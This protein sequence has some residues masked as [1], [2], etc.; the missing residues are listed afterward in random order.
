[1]GFANFV[2]FYCSLLQKCTWFDLSTNKIYNNNNKTT[3]K[4]I[5][6]G[7]KY[8]ITFSGRGKSSTK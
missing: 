7:L 5:G 8:D 4:W 1:M 2:Y 3:Q 6:C